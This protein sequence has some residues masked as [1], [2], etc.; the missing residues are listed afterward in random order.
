MKNI[1]WES[2]TS[3]YFLWLPRS[4]L[5]QPERRPLVK[6]AEKSAAEW[7]F[8]KGTW[9]NVFL[10]AV[11]CIL[12]FSCLFP[13]FVLLFRK[14][15]DECNHY[16]TS[17]YW[18]QSWLYIYKSCLSFHFE[19]YT[20]WQIL[21]RYQLDS[22]ERLLDEQDTSVMSFLYFNLIESDRFLS[23]SSPLFF[24]LVFIS[25]THLFFFPFITC[26]KEQLNFIQ[27]FPWWNINLFCFSCVLLKVLSPSLICSSS[28]S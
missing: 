28:L 24:F 18:L 17:K 13:L 9:H 6:E 21:E 19:T 11:F 26:L 8:E 3:F 23:S 12:I 2:L 14:S 20:W 1:K 4:K 7:D 22:F 25:I 10:A 5:V 15:F 16:R 27:Y